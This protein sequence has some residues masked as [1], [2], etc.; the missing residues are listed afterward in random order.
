MKYRTMT[1]YA[2]IISVF[3]LFGCFSNEASISEDVEI[4]PSIYATDCDPELISEEECFSWVDDSNLQGYYTFYFENSNVLESEG[5]FDNGIP[6]GFWK[7]YYPDGRLRLEGNFSNQQRNGFWKSYYANGFVEWEGNFNN[8]IREGYWKFY[9]TNGRVAEE[10]N[11]N[12]AIRNGYWKYYFQD[13][14]LE[15]EGN[16]QCF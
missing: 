8:C 15:W 14:I 16:Y 2:L 10:G 9:Y 13:G 4:I 11:F 1:F 6:S 7:F 12:N 5:N 3:G